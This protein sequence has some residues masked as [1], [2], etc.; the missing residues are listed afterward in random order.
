M[1]LRQCIVLLTLLPMSLFVHCQESV[2]TNLEIDVVGE[3][4]NN[5]DI[6][7]S[8]KIL[9]GDE[10]K[11]KLESNLGA[12]LANELGVSATGF[13]A[14]ASRPVIR[15]LDGSRVQILENG[16]T[17][18]D[19]SS[20]SADHAVADS[21]Q[22]ASQIE[23]LRGASA[24]MYGSG[25]SGGLINVLNDRIATVLPDKTMGGFNVNGGSSA[26]SRDD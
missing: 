24:L 14:G 25:S 16:M 4:P 21:I 10:L 2:E 12:T 3:R 20:I 1:Q 11:N 17:V 5:Q 6:T 23:I 9:Y 19:V 15:G 8:A 7:S 13:G 26:N 22:N 18:N